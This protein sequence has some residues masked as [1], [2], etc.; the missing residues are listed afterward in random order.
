MEVGGVCV[1]RLKNLHVLWKKD[2][3]KQQ[4]EKKG[5]EAPYTV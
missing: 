3:K 5:F 1:Y 4:E 2:E